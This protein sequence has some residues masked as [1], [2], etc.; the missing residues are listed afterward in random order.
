MHLIDILYYNN[1]VGS[2]KILLTYRGGGVEGGWEGQVIPR[3]LTVCR[4]PRIN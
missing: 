2:F 4:H 1:R 3:V